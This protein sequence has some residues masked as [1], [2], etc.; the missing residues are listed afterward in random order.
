MPRPTRSVEDNEPLPSG[1]GEDEIRR[2]LKAG[3]TV[4]QLILSDPYLPLINRL[5]WLFTEAGPPARKE[6]A[7]VQARARIAPNSDTANSRQ[8]RRKKAY[9]GV[10]VFLA[11]K[12]MRERL[13]LRN[14]LADRRALE[15]GIDMLIRKW[16]LFKPG[17]E[18][19]TFMRATSSEE[20]PEAFKLRVK[21][22]VSVATGLLWELA[23]ICKP[24]A[25]SP[26]R[27]AEF[28]DQLACNPW[29]VSTMLK[30][31][32]AE[33]WYF[34]WWGGNGNRRKLSFT[35]ID[36]GWTEDT[37]MRDAPHLPDRP[38]TADS[39]SAP[40]RRRRNPPV[41]ASKP[42]TRWTRRK[43][44]EA[45]EVEPV[46]TAEPIIPIAPVEPV[47]PTTRMRRNAPVR[48]PRQAAE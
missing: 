3:K 44:A 13:G 6:A 11:R 20:S 42:S 2:Q 32:M 9:A 17:P 34:D 10:D 5:A 12:T 21:R 40:K 41:K 19:G 38:R 8:R 48:A 43:P 24:D 4:R 1:I 30:R 36:C 16:K 28:A 29:T 33:T 25:P 47:I 31:V 22:R 46:A 18:R 14:A 15:R 7:R 27:I 35:A 39:D 37:S 23:D 45:A 26:H